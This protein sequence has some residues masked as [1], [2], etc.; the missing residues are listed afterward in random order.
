MPSPSLPRLPC[1]ARCRRSDEFCSSL[2][3]NA[4][5]IGLV[6]RPRRDERRVIACPAIFYASRV[7]GFSQ[8]HAGKSV[9]IRRFADRTAH[10]EIP[11]SPQK[12]WRSSGTALRGNL[13]GGR[14][15][16]PR[17]AAQT[18]PG[19][20]PAAGS[21]ARD[22]CQTPVY[23]RRQGRLSVRISRFAALSVCSARLASPGAAPCA[24]ADWP[25]ASGP[26][27]A[28]RFLDHSPE[29]T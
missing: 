19:A 10:G 29:S 3:A 20:P 6:Y 13:A 21:A 26:P 28:P 1:G 24:E 4:L 11:I 23:G 9:L 27:S 12:F 14:P 16:V 2:T 5:R 25:Q 18:P 22:R 15:I 17:R 8:F 7:A